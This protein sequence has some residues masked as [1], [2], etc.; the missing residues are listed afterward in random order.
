[1]NDWSRT[2]LEYAFYYLLGVNGGNVTGLS[3]D[4]LASVFRALANLDIMDWGTFWNDVL[5]S[6]NAE[7]C[8]VCPQSQAALGVEQNLG[9]VVDVRWPWLTLPASVVFLTASFLFI[10]PMDGYMHNV[11]V[12]KT[13]LLAHLVHGLPDEV[14]SS[15]G[16]NESQKISGMEKW[17]KTVVVRLE[18]KQHSGEQGENQWL[19]RKRLSP[20]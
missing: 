20:D 15:M 9:L 11:H 18:P 10:V 14:R 5:V 13:S 8:A 3:G 2:D 19:L 17:A 7:L 4:P 1:M 16:Q 6:M 12:W